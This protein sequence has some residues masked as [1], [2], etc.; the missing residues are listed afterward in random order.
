MKKSG[1]RRVW[2]GRLQEGHGAP[3]PEQRG[4]KLL[5]HLL[6]PRA[7]DVYVPPSRPWPDDPETLVHDVRVASRR[8]V[9]AVDLAGPLLPDKTRFRLRRTAKRFRQALGLRRQADVLL[10]DFRELVLRAGCPS[11]TAA[12]VAEALNQAQHTGLSDVRAEYG[13]KRLLRAGIRVVAATESTL[14]NLNW[15]QIGGPHLYLRA[16]TPEKRLAALA[17]P[18]QEEEHH[19]LR[20]D[21]KRLRYAAEILGEVFPEEMAESAQLRDLKRIQDALGE[22]QDGYDLLAFIQRDEVRGSADETQLKRLEDLARAHKDERHA[23]ARDVV[24]RRAPDVLGGLRRAAGRI[25]QLEI[26]A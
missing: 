6:V 11:E 8:L 17:D 1:H 3:Q 16:T 18:T 19:D 14:Q 23:R 24:Q 9:E 2:L 26:A 13:P 15:R 5:R 12:R 22:L 7:H 10:A 25:G 4:S 20:V 21:F